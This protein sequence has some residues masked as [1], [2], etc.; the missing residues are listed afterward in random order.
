MP[1]LGRMKIQNSRHTRQVGS[2][3]KGGTMIEANG[4]QT[5]GPESVGS[6]LENNTTQTTSQP[7][8]GMSRKDKDHEWSRLTKAI[9]ERYSGCRLDN[10]EVTTD[11]Q[12]SVVGSLMRFSEELEGNIKSGR[13][14]VLYGPPG[15]GKD[16][17][18]V[19]M[20]HETV[21]IG[22]TVKWC[23]GM[24]LFAER[25]DY[26]QRQLAEKDL[27]REYERPDVLVIS[28]PVPPWGELREGQSEFLFRLID[29]RYRR[30]KPIF[31]SANFANSD[32]AKSRIGSQVLDRLKHGS[33]CC[34]CKWESYRQAGK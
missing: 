21:K 32:D 19:G 23:N 16:H 4:N 18:L 11:A 31:V 29:W 15:V 7:S 2:I 14:I 27:L 22:L 8:E 3:K 33:L 28:D 30:L 13:G 26:I 12:K 10:F 34:H 9:G 25:R 1:S 17:L 20:S 24:D 6:L 5:A